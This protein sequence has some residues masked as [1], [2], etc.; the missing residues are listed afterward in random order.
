[1]VQA[2]ELLAPHP[3]A[4]QALIDN[5]EATQAVHIPELVH[6]V[7]T[8]G[9]VQLCLHLLSNPPPLPCWRATTNPL[10]PAS[11]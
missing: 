7:R 2:L 10:A 4:L 11:P 3:A 9:F 8:E 6:A 1:M 5:C